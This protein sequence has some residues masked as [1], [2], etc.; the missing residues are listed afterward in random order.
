VTDNPSATEKSYQ[1]LYQAGVRSFEHGDYKQAIA[2]FQQALNGVN[3]GTKI[4]GEIQVWLANAYDAAGN[5][6]EAIAL[7]RSL[8]KHSDRDV[9]KSASYVLGILSA[10]KLNTLKDANS[11]IPSLKGLDDQTLSRSIG[12]S[13]AK[14][15]RA[16]SENQSSTRSSIDVQK[17]QREQN[18]F[19]GMAISIILA[20]LVIWAIN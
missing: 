10:P 11:K 15:D 5:P 2:H 18:L 19:L 8:K 7:C 3:A 12:S 13:G 20:G 9:R 4:G 17:S 14:S 6:T 1:E 16:K